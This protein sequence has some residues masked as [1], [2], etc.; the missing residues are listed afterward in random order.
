MVNANG[1][2]GGFGTPGAAAYGGGYKSPYACAEEWDGTS[3]AS[4]NAINVARACLEGGGTQNAGLIFGGSS[5]NTGTCTESYNGTTWSA[6][7]AMSNLRC[8]TTG[9]GA[10]PVS[11]T[12]LTLPTNREV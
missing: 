10:A 1:Y 3:W 12:H 11:Y 8:L 4:G 2:V 7:N 5:N 9:G 6:T